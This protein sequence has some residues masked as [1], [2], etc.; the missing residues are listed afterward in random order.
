MRSTRPASVGGYCSGVT[1]FF[2]DYSWL[3]EHQL[4]VAATLAHANDL[5]ASAADVLHNY[6]RPGPLEF[7]NAIDGDMAHVTVVAVAPLPEAVSRY[8]ADGLTQLRA[9]IEHTLFAEVERELGREL[10]DV[11][12]RRIE[13]PACTTPATF[14]KWLSDRHRPDLAPL[15]DGTLLVARMRDLQPYQRRDVDEHPLRV[16]AEH[17]NH[18][19]H[20]APAV[21][22]TQLGV[23]I[24]DR[25]QVG[26]LV[27]QPP[28]D[29]PLQPGDVLASGPLD[30]S[31]GLSIWPKVSVQRPHTRTWHVVLAEL[32]TLEDWVRRIAIP[33]LLTG[34]HDISILPPGLDTK[35][36]HSDVRSALLN[37]ATTPAAERAS[38]RI[39]ADSARAGLSETLA[40]HAAAPEK[41]RVDIWAHSLTDDEVLERVDRL[42]APA[43][44]GDLAGIDIAVRALLIEVNAPN[45]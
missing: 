4:H 18:A 41:S 7:T 32:G 27:H 20:R 1:G 6:L 38:R 10:D 17:N 25:N 11:E 15:R 12:S 13:M 31:V 42:S 19:K 26:L 43:R 5:I 40:S 28:Q 14:E 39:Q 33:H 30:L 37:A 29:R 16:L 36:G 21:A 2:R 34:R 24:P 3:P 45:R 44:T 8:V 23:V 35:S 9:A 22:A